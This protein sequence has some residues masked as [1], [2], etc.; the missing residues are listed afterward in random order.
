MGIN[1]WVNQ[2]VV[3]HMPGDINWLTL[4]TGGT[5]GSHKH[6]RAKGSAFSHIDFY[7]IENSSEDTCPDGQQNTSKLSGK[8][9]GTQN[10]DLLCLSK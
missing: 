2:G 3:D 9:R 1:G 5:E 4:I 7:K 6:T 10:K 8:D